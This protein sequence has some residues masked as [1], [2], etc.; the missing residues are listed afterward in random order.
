MNETHYLLVSAGDVNVLGYNL[1]T[2][3]ES[4]EA[5]LPRIQ[6]LL[7]KRIQIKLSQCS[8]FNASMHNNIMI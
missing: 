1:T 6:I 8:C 7:C 5:L 2:M 3:K 4:T